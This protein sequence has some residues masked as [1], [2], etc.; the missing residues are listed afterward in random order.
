M[1]SQPLLLNMLPIVLI[2]GI[3]YFMVLRPMNKR[4]TAVRDFQQSLKVGDRII[5]TSGIHGQITKLNDKTVKVQIAD[6]V[7]IEV[8]R[9]AVGGL[10]G[11]E[12]LVPVGS[13]SNNSL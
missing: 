8:A 10:Q 13:D 2:V 7:V 1:L 12:P 5:M 9:A 11:A 3:F 4:Q 6:R